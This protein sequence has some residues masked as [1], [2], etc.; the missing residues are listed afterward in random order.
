MDGGRMHRGGASAAPAGPRT[1]LQRLG[2][3]RASA[4]PLLGA[5]AIVCTLL[6]AMH[7]DAQHE[8]RRERMEQEWEQARP[9]LGAEQRRHM[10]AQFVCGHGV[11]YQWVNGDTV[12]CLRELDP[13][14][15][16]GL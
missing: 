8:L 11:A 2:P 7:E 10:A 5:V 9:P 16:R 15:A 3:T 13:A 1:L 12:E 4:M 6:W 14:V